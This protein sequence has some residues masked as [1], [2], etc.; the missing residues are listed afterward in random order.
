M[1]DIFTPPANPPVNHSPAGP[2]VRVD[3]SRVVGQSHEPTTPAIQRFAD[4]QAAAVAADPWLDPNMVLTRGADGT[5]TARP[6][7]D[8]GV[9]GTP[10]AGDQPASPG[11]Q[12]QPAP[13]RIRVGDLELTADDLKGLMERRGLE[14]SR[15]ATL[16]KDAASYN[17]DLPADFRLPDGVAWQWNLNDPVLTPLIGQA[18]E[19]AFANG[20]N[21]EG[22]SKMMSLYA[23]TQL[24]EGQMIARARVAEVDKLGA[25]AP[26]RVDAV[27]MFL[28]GNLG[29]AHAKAITSGLHTAKQI[30]AFETLMQRFTNQ[31]G[32]S[33]S[34]AH[35]EVNQPERLSNEAYNK[36]TYTEKKDYAANFGQR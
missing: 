18:K 22:F 25:T 7:A 29:D 10:D 19:W 28:R 2:P 16:P 30:E 15:K 35:R 21:Q 4:Q 12:Q 27:S 11:D 24:H 20:V 31:G 33:Y 26:A 13:D 6:R 23:A 9:N 34:G 17:L 32:G 3:G 5:I 14:E 36:L 8:G 1:N